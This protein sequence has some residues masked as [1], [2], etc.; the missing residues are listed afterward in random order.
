MDWASSLLAASVKCW[1]SNKVYSS[2]VCSRHFIEIPNVFH[3]YLLSGRHLLRL[4]E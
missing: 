2:N 3:P 4:G 1:R